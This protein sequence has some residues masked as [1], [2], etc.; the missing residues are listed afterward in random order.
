MSMWQQMATITKYTVGGV[1]GISVA[2]L[3]FEMYH[4]AILFMRGGSNAQKREEAKTHMVHIAIAGI[5][6]GSSGV[7]LD[8]IL[9]LLP[10][11]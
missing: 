6:I 1:G 10:S 5:V 4:V 7:L 9:H 11:S 8:V 2:Y 3:L